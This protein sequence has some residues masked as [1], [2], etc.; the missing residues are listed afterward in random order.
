MICLCVSREPNTA[1]VNRQGK[2]RAHVPNVTRPQVASDTNVDFVTDNEQLRRLCARV[3]ENHTFAFDTEFVMEDRFTPEIS[4]VQLAT[5]EGRISLIDPHVVDDL[6][7]LWRLVC[8]PDIITV[9]HAGMEDLALCFN[10]SGDVPRNIFDCQL[11]AG[12]VSTEYPLSLSRLARNL[13]RVRLHKSQT[14][15]DWNRRPLT[16][17]QIEYAAADVH[18]LLEI[19]QKIMRRLKKFDRLEW[20]NEEMARF[21]EAATYQRAPDEAALRLKGAR[22]LDARQLAVARELV[23]V[24]ERL[25]HQYNRP[26]RAVVRDHLLIEIAR[27]GWTKPEQIRKLRGLSLR[28][29]ALRELAA[30]VRTAMDLPRD[31]WPTVD[32]PF[33]ET[34]TEAALSLVVSGVIRAYCDRN[35]IA[36][37]LVASRQAV[38]DHVR[39][40][41]RGRNSDSPLARGWRAASVGRIVDDLLS[42]ESSISVER[43]SSE[44][45]LR[46]LR[47]TAPNE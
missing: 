35:R 27:H 7:P 10:R 36:H 17:E 44:P 14:L 6:S 30:G 45:V 26:V 23:K 3:A 11:A 8:D 28:S 34:E 12:L 9:V 37:Q 1:T 18:H 47:R 19:H 46:I 5:S 29:D 32:E 40:V 39:S 25:A 15:T 38:R 4:L 43:N 20:L 22:G 31:Q 33:E 16:E 2:A 13:L 21:S 42:G 24:R 41:L